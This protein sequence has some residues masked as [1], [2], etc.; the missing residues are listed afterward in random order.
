MKR[1]LMLAP[2]ALLLLALDAAAIKDRDNQGRWEK[3]VESGPDREVP[4]F[5]VN[6]GPTGARAVLT[7]KTF[8]VRFLFKGAPGD[9]RLRVG[10]VITGVF[11]KPFS[12]HTFGGE[13]HGYEGP[14]LDLGEAIERAEGKDGRLLL[15]VLRGSEAVEVAVPLEPVGTFAPSFPMQCRKS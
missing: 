4:G 10:D 7:E 12:S 3:R 15:N 6:L 11:G 9:G 1:V 13:P 8:V 14:I 5:L 2:A